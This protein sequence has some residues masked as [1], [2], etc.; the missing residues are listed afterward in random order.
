[1]ETSPGQTSVARKRLRRAL[2]VGFPSPHPYPA[3][4]MKILLRQTMAKGSRCN[5]SLTASGSPPTFAV[6]RYSI[7]STLR[8]H[9]RTVN[10]RPSDKLDKSLTLQI[11]NHGIK[12]YMHLAI[13]YFG[14]EFPASRTAARVFMFSHRKKAECK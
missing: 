4:C 5:T 9:A 6:E 11:P 14:N 12:A 2:G 3:R 7:I 13:D 8:L 1:M 10:L